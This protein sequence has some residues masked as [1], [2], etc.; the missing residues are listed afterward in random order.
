MDEE[1]L[2]TFSDNVRDVVMTLSD[3]DKAILV[4]LYI[5]A[6]A[7]DKILCDMESSGERTMAIRKINIQTEA[8]IKE[9][10]NNKDNKNEK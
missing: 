6:K 7:I 3:A 8:K 5:N 10:L 1:I 9:I 2:A 4:I